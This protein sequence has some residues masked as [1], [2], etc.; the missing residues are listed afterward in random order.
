MTKFTIKFR[1][2]HGDT[3]CTE[4]TAH[5]TADTL[6]GLA[7][8]LAGPGVTV[9]TGFPP[10]RLDLSSAGSTTLSDLGISSGDTITLQDAGAAEASASAEASSRAP[11]STPFSHKLFMKKPVP[12]DNSCLFTSIGL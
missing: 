6:L 11:P 12:A 2:K 1:T 7:E 5:T 8:G 10:K 4:L 9:L 3:V